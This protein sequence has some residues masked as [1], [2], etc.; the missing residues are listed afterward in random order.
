MI[1]R[2]FK[3]SNS[4]M[5]LGMLF[6]AIGSSSNL[7]LRRSGLVSENLVDLIAGLFLGLA[8]PTLLLSIVRRRSSPPRS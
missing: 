3:N 2:R 6:M 5:C 4:I 8:I 1:L 7:L